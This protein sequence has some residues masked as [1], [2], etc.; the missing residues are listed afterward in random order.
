MTNLER[1]KLELN[2]KEYFTDNEYKIFLSENG[3]NGDDTYNKDLNQR[4]LL[5]TVVDILEAVANDVDL[6]RKIDTEFQTTSQAIK[7][8][9]NRIEKIRNRIMDIED[10]DAGYSNVSLLFTRK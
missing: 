3:L 6:M 1:L 8:L 2:H 10:A 7:Y 4:D 5:Y 9:E